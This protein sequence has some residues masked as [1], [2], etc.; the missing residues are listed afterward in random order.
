MLWPRYPRVFRRFFRLKGGIKGGILWD[1]LLG[2]FHIGHSCLK[3]SCFFFVNKNL[4]RL[5]TVDMC[6][7]FFVSPYS[8]P[9]SKLKVRQTSEPKRWK[10]WSCF[11]LDLC[12]LAPKI[13]GK[14]KLGASTAAAATA[15]AFSAASA[16]ILASASTMGWFF[17]PNKKLGVSMCLPKTTSTFGENFGYLMFFDVICWFGM[18]W[19]VVGTISVSPKRHAKRASRASSSSFLLRLRRPRRLRTWSLKKI[20]LHRKTNEKVWIVIHDQWKMKNREANKTVDDLAR[21]IY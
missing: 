12:V 2:I 13:S 4:E 14:K 8:N 18:C 16:T 6:W 19:F 21:I 1:E 10:C 17:R 20:E 7:S 3:G 11:P 15:A 9:Y 5:Y